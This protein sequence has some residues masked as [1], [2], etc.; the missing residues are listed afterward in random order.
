L[1]DTIKVPPEMVFASG[2]GLDPDISPESALLQVD[3]VS[4]VRNFTKDQKDK[5]LAYITANSMSTHFSS[6]GEPRINVLLLN[7][8]LDK[9]AL[10]QSGT[11]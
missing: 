1:P 3:R 7:M 2:S 8:A 9:I 10:A 11:N 6:L 5:L 4:S